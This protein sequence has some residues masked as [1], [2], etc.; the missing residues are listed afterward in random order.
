MGL[1]VQPQSR[2]TSVASVVRVGMVRLKTLTI[3]NIDNTNT[4]NGSVN[5]GILFCQM[6]KIKV[7]SLPSGGRAA[8]G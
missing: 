3:K 1:I 6:D 2:V 7:D 4:N 5:S 8:A